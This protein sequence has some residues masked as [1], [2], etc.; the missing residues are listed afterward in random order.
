[1]AASKNAIHV[2][3]AAIEN[4]KGEILIAKRPTH[5]HQGGLWE[6]PGGKVEA[7]ETIE[8]A[9]QREL[10]EELN[11]HVTN[12]TPLIQIEHHYPDKSV[13]LDVRHVITFTGTA[14]G[15]EGQDTQWVNKES[16][17]D[18]E[19]PAA[20]KSIIN[21]ILLPSEYLITPEHNIVDRQWFLDTLE[22]RLVEGIELLQ[23]RA[24]SLSSDEFA[25][26][27]NQVKHLTSQY[28]T[29]LLV[30]TSLENAKQL[31][32]SGVH[33]TSTTLLETKSLP[34]NLTI[35]ASCHNANEIIK[36]NELGVQFILISPV[37][38]TSSHP[39]A[40]PMGWDNF[41]NLCRIST[42]PA[43]AL[44]GMTTTDAVTAISHGGQGIAGISS[45]W[46][47]PEK[48]SR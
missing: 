46:K 42:V 20:N 14:I 10:L 18:F 47:R 7:N 3:A 45:L 1:M 34:K 43:F 16:L 27:Y 33:L 39:E 40:T 38:H 5:V 44:G 9:L 15:N 11:I 29:K 23:L 30:N 48:T 35:A 32:A 17:I 22:S 37:N 19:F 31:G 4:S 28:N 21:A 25:V 13:F 2:V 41:A 6:F 26:L 24:K 12:S 8:S 36:A